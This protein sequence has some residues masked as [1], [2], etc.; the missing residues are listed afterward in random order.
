MSIVIGPPDALVGGL[1]ATLSSP[2]KAP[3]QVS[4]GPFAGRRRF[5]AVT[6][7][8][9]PPQKSSDAS[10]PRLSAAPALPISAPELAING[11][12]VKFTSV[13]L[14]TVHIK[15]TKDGVVEF[16]DNITHEEIFA[17][18]VKGLNHISDGTIQFGPGYLPFARRRGVRLLF[19]PN[20]QT[21]VLMCFLY[22][23]IAVA[24]YCRYS[25]DAWKTYRALDK[26]IHGPYTRTTNYNATGHATSQSDPI[27][28][29][30]PWHPDLDNYEKK[31]RF[32]SSAK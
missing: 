20:R 25:M 8:S 27:Y 17:E 24:F 4:A 1:F 32:S 14:E 22:F 26:D 15:V 6:I 23:F 2:A 19:G 16:D 30:E 28:Q 11:C 5:D 29:K 18:C 21:F 10:S 31:G 9:P 12:L 3:P 7:S 13:D